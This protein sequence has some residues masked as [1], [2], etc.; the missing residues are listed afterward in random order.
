MGGQVGVD[1]APG[2]GSNFW[3]A[4]DCRLPDATIL[5]MPE[6]SARSR[7]LALPGERR[8]NLLVVEDNQINQV[9]IASMLRTAGH[10]CDIAKDGG[11]AIEAVQKSPYDGVL[12]DI[13]MPVIDGVEATQRI[14]TLGDTYA[15]LPII[16]LT[17]NAMAGDEERY[18]GLGMNDYVAKPI[19]PDR[20]T[21]ALRRSIATDA[22]A[23]RR[24]EL[25]GAQ[26]PAA[27]PNE[28][29]DLKQL[30]GSL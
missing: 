15:K 28:D 9:V 14:R 30:L 8:L 26:E 10:E 22:A 24:G 27:D 20:L 21:L 6:V 17:A 23:I 25:K 12:M 18:L 7:L 13:Q 11:E 16:A 5:P 29:D 19:D 1:S 3:F 2:K 4:A